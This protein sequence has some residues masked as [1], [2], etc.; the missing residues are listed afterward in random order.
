MGPSVVP[1]RLM[2]RGAKLSLMLRNGKLF[3]LALVRGHPLTTP[4]TPPL[5]LRR[6]SLPRI[7]PLNNLPALILIACLLACFLGVVQSEWS[8]LGGESSLNYQES[9][10]LFTAQQE[11]L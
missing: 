11:V 6:C 3:P 8:L 1:L 5:P 7:H 9:T 4:P 2:M 10:E